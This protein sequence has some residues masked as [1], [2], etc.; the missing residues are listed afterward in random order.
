MD[1]RVRTTVPTGGKLMRAKILDLITTVSAFGLLVMLVISVIVVGV[2]LVVKNSTVSMV[3]FE[4]TDMQIV[5]QPGDTLW[6]IARLQMPDEDPRDVVGAIRD[7]NALETANIYP[8][9][10]L[11]LQVKQAVKPLHMAEG[12]SL[13]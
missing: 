8:G 6:S 2:Q 4:Y 5:V 11:T 1:L 9:Q 12:N 3:G 13:E 10:I 7:L